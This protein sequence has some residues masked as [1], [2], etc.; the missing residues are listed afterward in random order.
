MTSPPPDEADWLRVEEPSAPAGVRRRV[1]ALAE[2]L[3]FDAERLGQVQLA[4]TEAATNLVK[5]AERGEMLVRIVRDGDRAEVEIVCLDRGPGIADV[6]LSLLDGFSTAGSLGVGLGAIGR[7]ADRSG[8]YSHPGGGT[9]L[10]ARFRQPGSPAGDPP[11]AGLTRPI[12]G[13]RECGDAYAVRVFGRAVHALLCDGLGHG[14][15]AAR[16]SAEAVR[17]VRELTAP[18]RPRDLLDL[19][20]RRLTATRGGAVAVATV[21]LDDRTVRFA[22]IG[23]VAGWIVAPGGRQGLV[24]TPGIA[25]E[26]SRTVREYEYEL[27]AGASVVL[28]SDGLTDRWDLSDRP[29][30]LGRDPLLLAGVLI[31]DAGTRHD[32]RAVLVV[33]P[34]DRP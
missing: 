21:D 15:L 29:G 34:G 6:P 27:P 17:A 8:L 20:H 22:G 13:E 28:H 9:V 5:H 24:S 10:F 3:G 30:V 7:L 31:R 18:I 1:T 12:D 26:R 16:A 14:P 25:G 32:D 19:V 4:A 23:N 2:R 33:G 11:F